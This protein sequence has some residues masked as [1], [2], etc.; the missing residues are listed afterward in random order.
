NGV[1]RII[2]VKA[3]SPVTGVPVN[4]TQYNSNNFFGT[5]GTEFTADDEYV[6]Y[7]STSNSLTIMNLQPST[8]YHVSI[9]GYNGQN[10]TTEY[11]MVPLS[12]S[13]T[14]ASPPTTQAHSFVFSNIIGNSV[15][16]SWT[17]GNG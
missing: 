2:V 13:V 7:R 9:F 8:T 12:G 6:V 15:K 5:A 1:G 17:N 14:T 3:L 16:V 10:A 4:G 11:L